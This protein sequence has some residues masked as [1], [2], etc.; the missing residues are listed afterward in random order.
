MRIQQHNASTMRPI[1]AARQR[2][3]QWAVRSLWIGL[4]LAAPCIA[5]AQG[6]PAKKG[7]EGPPKPE[8]LT[9]KTND[10][11]S[12]AL[13][14]YPGTKGKDSIPVVLLHAWKQSG[15]DYKALASSLQAMGCA[16]LVPDLRGH[17]ASTRLQHGRRDETLNPANMPP[18][19]FAAM[20]AQD[21]IA[22]K[23][24]LW[25]RNNAGELNIDKLCVV[26]AEMGAAVALNFAAADALEQDRN[27]VRRPEYQ[28]GR[29][30]KALVLI[31]PELTFRGLSIRNATAYPAVQKDISVLILA[32]RND[33]KAWEEAKRI[34]GIFERFHPEPTG[35]D[36]LDRK[37]LFIV[38]FPT[39]LQGAKLLDPKLNMPAL[40]GE[41]ITRRLVKSK[42]SREWTWQERSVPHG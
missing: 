10:G 38:G 20:V 28:V 40:I 9:L 12:L 26:G 41:F 19:Q 18:A 35:D 30:V 37:T 7:K 17:G 31:S 39:S 2:W 1:S 25:D 36:K 24:F 21:M 29:F 32:G 22:I 8:L 4:A 34:H 33:G 5:L 3:T 15:N 6:A 42:E 16:V 23:R 13:T 27:R 11:L 14:F